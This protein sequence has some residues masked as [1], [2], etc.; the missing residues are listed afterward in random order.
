MQNIFKTIKKWVRGI[1]LND[2][3]VEARAKIQKEKQEKLEKVIGLFEEK[4]KITNDDVERVL[5]VSNT[6]AFRYL[7][8]L[9]K[10]GKIKQV[11]ETGQAVFYIK[12]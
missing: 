2:L 6:T 11:G 3:L 9:E 7:E 8:R 10:Q 5:S 12:N 4:E 1:F